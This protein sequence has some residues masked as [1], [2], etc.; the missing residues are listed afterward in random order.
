MS[1]VSVSASSKLYSAVYCSVSYCDEYTNILSGLITSLQLAI[2][3]QYILSCFRYKYDC[4][5][6]SFNLW[7]FLELLK[8]RPSPKKQTWKMFSRIYQA[9]L[10]DCTAGEIWSLACDQTLWRSLEASWLNAA[11]NE[12]MQWTWRNH[13]L[14]ES[15][16]MCRA[17][18]P[19]SNVFTG[20]SFTMCVIYTVFQKISP[21]LRLRYNLFYPKPIL[22]IFGRNVAKGVCSIKVLCLLT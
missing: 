10:C 16:A 21:P 13:S 20:Q 17:G 1:K 2:F 14:A 18:T 12:H 8:V 6:F 22:I 9:R 19:P 15:D 5:Q 3:T 7:V 11:V 4:F